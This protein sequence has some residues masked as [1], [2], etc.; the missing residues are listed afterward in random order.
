VQRIAPLIGPT[1]FEQGLGIE[2]AE[3]VKTLLTFETLTEIPEKTSAERE[4]VT[5]PAG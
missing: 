4:T 5:Q 1:G 3:R 2:D